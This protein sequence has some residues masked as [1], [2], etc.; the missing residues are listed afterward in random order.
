M[1]KNLPYS[2]SAGTLGKLLN[3]ITTASE[4][5][6]F[7]QD[8]VSTKLGMKGGTARGCIPFIKKM[9][10]VATDG[11]PTDLYRKFRNPINSKKAIAKCIKKLYA[12]L[13]EMNEYVHEASDAEIKG[14]IIQFTGAEK[15]SDVLK[16][17][18]YT[19]NLLKNMADFES[20]TV[21]EVESEPTDII[22]CDETQNLPV[23]TDIPQFNYPIGASK[24]VN[25]SYT[26]NLNLPATKEIEV[27]NAIFKSLKEHIL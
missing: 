15:K 19:F 7:S 1:T 24:K 26:I 2:Y 22:E 20:S 3:K 5:E 10:L 23:T 13:Y 16:R 17:T 4:P 21:E 6:R 14:L 25:M 12:P 27:F 11:T 9:G 8:F 18:L